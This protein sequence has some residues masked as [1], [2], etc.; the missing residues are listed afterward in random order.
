M[1]VGSAIAKLV[2]HSKWSKEGCPVETK[3]DNYLFYG[4][5]V[6]IGWIILCIIAPCCGFN[7]TTYIVTRTTTRGGEVI[8]KDV[9]EEERGG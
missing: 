5:L 7:P 9:K 6:D 3:V 2:I 4:G 1:Y 8:R